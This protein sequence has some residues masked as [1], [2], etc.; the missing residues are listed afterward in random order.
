MTST[1][2]TTIESEAAT[3]EQRPLVTVRAIA[4]GT[5]LSLTNAL[6]GGAIG[7]TVT[8]SRGL[9]RHG[10]GG[11]SLDVRQAIAGVVATAGQTTVQQA[12]AQAILSAG[13]VTMNQAGSGFAVGRSIRIE[14][15][16]IVV[17]GL[18]PRIDVHRGGRVV[19]GTKASLAL[20]GG[21]GT[22][23]AVVTMML[24]RGGRAAA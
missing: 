6:V 15:Q 1:T 23:L 3:S 19:F 10:Y 13:S 4:R 16:G 11:R 18:A 7:E 12:G 8:V 2:T 14:R 21:L 9:I 20:I 24:R 5:E 17:F 22:L